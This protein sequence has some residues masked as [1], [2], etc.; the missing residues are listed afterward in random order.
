MQVIGAWNLTVHR[1]SHLEEGELSIDAECDS[2]VSVTKSLGTNSVTL[3]EIYSTNSMKG[4]FKKTVKKIL[5]TY[6]F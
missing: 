2:L 1:S 5:P 3:S 4:A 6:S